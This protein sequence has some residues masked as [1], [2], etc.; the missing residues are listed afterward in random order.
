[1]HDILDIARRRSTGF[2]VASLVL[3]LAGCASSPPVHFHTLMPSQTPARNA[4]PPLPGAIMLEPVRVPAQVDQPQWLIRMPDDSVARLEQE[5]WASPL[6]D[7]IRGAVTEWLVDRHGAT[8]A[9]PAAVPS[10]IVRISIDLRRFESAPAREVRL[11]G[12]WTL[13]GGGGAGSPRSAASCELLVREPT[14]DG[15]YAA[16]ATAQRRAVERLADTI[17]HSLR[18]IS[19]GE[20]LICP[21]SNH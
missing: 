11:E 9:T 13:T 16:L 21:A 1:M 18:S 2:C 20:P 15:S 3:V 6:R 19:R 14:A 8:E 12:F 10:S 5:R 7:E 17:G 4:E